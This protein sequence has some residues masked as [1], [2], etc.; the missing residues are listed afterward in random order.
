MSAYSLKSAYKIYPTV[1]DNTGAGLDRIIE[2]KYGSDVDP[3][4]LASQIK[5]S[6]DVEWAEPR[7]IYKTSYVPSDPSFSKQWSL[8]KINATQAWDVAKG[9]T[10]IIIG[11]VDTGIDWDHPDLA[12]NIWTNK[13]EIPGNG[14][15][16]DNNGYVDDVR[17]WDFGGSTGTPDNNPMEDKPD[18]GTHVAG[19]ASAVTD[20]GVGVASIGGNSKLMAVKTSTNSNR[21]SNG[22]PYISYGYEGIV[23]AVDNGAKIINCSWGGDGYSMDGET[24]IKYALAKGA[25]VVAAAGN[26][27]TF[28]R[29]LPCMLPWSFISR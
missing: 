10:S 1:T 15:D 9:D 2:I 26:D 14:I 16:D 25:L 11:I 13:K 29:F 23:Y 21:D 6:A 12:A 17:G 5:K 20:N 24:V 19:I 3:Q 22:N 28:R 27:M 18:H 7:Y 8:T 4:Y